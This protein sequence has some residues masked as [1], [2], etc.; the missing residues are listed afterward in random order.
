VTVATCTQLLL[1]QPLST[2]AGVLPHVGIRVPEFD[3]KKLGVSDNCS[4]QGVKGQF[5][6]IKPSNHPEA[7]L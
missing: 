5:M 2:G 6:H 3:V 4:Y 7:F 1:P